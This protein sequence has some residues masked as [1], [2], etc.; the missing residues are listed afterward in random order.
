MT[1][2]GPKN[3]FRVTLA[4]TD[5]LLQGFIRHFEPDSRAPISGEFFY[6]Y[7]ITYFDVQSDQISALYFLF[8]GGGGARLGPYFSVK[9]L[10]YCL[11][12]I[13]SFTNKYRESPLERSLSLRWLVFL[14]TTLK[15]NFSGCKIYDPGFGRDLLVTFFYMDRKSRKLRK[16]P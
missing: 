6:C 1:D 4:D 3:S 8:V 15:R 16:I 9:Q 2:F 12:S 14:R 10:D 7:Y 11:S 13:L 5:I